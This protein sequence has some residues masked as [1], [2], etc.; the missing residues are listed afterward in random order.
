MTLYWIILI[1][2]VVISGVAGLFLGCLMHQRKC[3][4]CQLAQMREQE[5]DRYIEKIL[6]K[7]HHDMADLNY[8]F[9]KDFNPEDDQ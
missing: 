7:P 6:P 3:A 5:A 8:L 9:S 1:V 2:A 4:E